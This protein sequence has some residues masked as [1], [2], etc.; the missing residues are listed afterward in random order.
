MEVIIAYCNCKSSEQLVECFL[1]PFCTYLKFLY[2]IIWHI[3]SGRYPSIYLSISIE[4]VKSLDPTLGYMYE[5][6]LE[7]LSMYDGRAA[8]FEFSL[9]NP[10]GL[11]CA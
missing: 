6:H 7:A 2:L 3:L 11:E 10:H 4:F 5:K 9:T 1:K 8:F